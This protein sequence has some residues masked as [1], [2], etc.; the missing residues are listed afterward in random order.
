M[1]RALAQAGADVVVRYHRN[2]DL[3]NRLVVELR[4]M[5]RRAVA[6]QAAVTVAAAV[7]ARRDAMVRQ[8]GPPGIIVTNAVFQYPWET[9]AGAVQRGL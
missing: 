4:G 2:I 5:N 7:N 9:R 3:A 8:L 1:V 6:V